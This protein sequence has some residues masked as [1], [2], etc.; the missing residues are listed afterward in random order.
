MPGAQTKALP[1][2]YVILAH[3]RPDDS[4]WTVTTLAHND[5]AKVREMVAAMR[6]KGVDAWP[7]ELVPVEEK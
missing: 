1:P 2:R 5:L 7:F 4:M 3:V 6:E